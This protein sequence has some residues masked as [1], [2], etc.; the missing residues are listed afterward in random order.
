M[1]T[2]KPADCVCN[3]SGH[4]WA[5]LDAGLRCDGTYKGR[6]CRASTC[7]DGLRCGAPAPPPS[8]RRAPAMPQPELVDEPAVQPRVCTTAAGLEDALQAS[9]RSAPT[10]PAMLTPRER[11]D[12]KERHE[13]RA[14]LARV[15]ASTE[16]Y[17]ARALTLADL[18]AHE[19]ARFSMRRA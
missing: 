13:E 11:A 14:Q 10:P 17:P 5:C 8:S 12:R 15:R 2:N 19:R 1:S 4:C 16:S 18:D 3:Y 9:L 7:A 6:P